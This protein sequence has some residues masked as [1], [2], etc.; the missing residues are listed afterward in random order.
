ME[1]NVEPQ[2]LAPGVKDGS[3]AGL[4]TQTFP[5]CGQFDQ[6]FGDSLEQEVIEAFSVP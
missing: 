6:A 5:A 1:M 3:E 4:G 2:F